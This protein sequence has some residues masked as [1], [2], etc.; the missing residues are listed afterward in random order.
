MLKITKF[1]GSSTASS[2]QFKKIKAIIESDEARRYVCVSAAGRRFS[3]DNKVTDLLYL[4]VAHRDYHVDFSSLLNDIESR[5][6]EIKTELGLSYPVEEKFDKL[7]ETIPTDS[8]QYIISRGEQLTAH[9]MAEYLGYD[10]LDAAEVIRFHHD[11][12]L[13]QE[14]TK[15]LICQAVKKH[16]H[17]VIPGFYGGTNDGQIKLL[18]R[19]G[20]DI[21]G[22][23]LAAA[24]NADLYENWTDVSGFMS[25]DPRIVD[26]PT[27]IN[28]I[29]FDEMQELSY[30]G[31]SVLHEEAIYPVRGSNIPIQIK[32]T[33]DPEATG[34][35]I[36]EYWNPDPEDPLITGIA[37]KKDFLSIYVAKTKMSNSVGFMRT[38]L[39][40][41]EKYGVSIE[42]VPT[43]I[44]SLSV[45]VNSK[46]VKN[47]IYSIIADIKQELHPDS[48]QLND[49]LALISVVGRNMPS[50]AGTSG[51]LL[52]VIGKA[53]IN[54]R[55]I[56]QSAQERT[57]VIG[58]ENTDFEHCVK[59]IYNEFVASEKAGA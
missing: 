56:S 16:D 1:G 39:S 50:K 21:T 19:G 52:G 32:N 46:D 45:V 44:D 38:V 14:A 15:E 2:E 30:M 13:D 20:G 5:F 10:Y 28:K 8:E 54:V 43:G 59:T 41:F 35:T 3:G 23:L 58:V 25:A 31:A 36:R 55:M 17:F 26:N 53:G 11:G 40:I 33:N 18:D 6:V 42:H 37:G 4:V 7:R 22:S 27:P 34:T 49:H 9:L 47:N 57:I 24:L 12:T 29:T 51:R 48:V